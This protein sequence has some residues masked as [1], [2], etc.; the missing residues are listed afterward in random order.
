MRIVFRR[1]CHTTFLYR[2]FARQTYGY[3]KTTETDLIL[4][5]KYHCLNILLFVPMGNHSLKCNVV[6][7]KLYKQF[8]E[9]L[10]ILGQTDGSRDTQIFMNIDAVNI[11]VRAKFARKH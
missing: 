4:Q 6:L 2:Y 8:S 3:R 11:C 9:W 7:E 1:L 5:D 10:T